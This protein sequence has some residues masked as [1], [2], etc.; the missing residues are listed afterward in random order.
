MYRAVWVQQ[1]SCVN[2][3]SGGFE[4][5]V[6]L[7]PGDAP[8]PP[9]TAAR[10]K[11]KLPIANA[12]TSA[13][14]TRVIC[15]I[16]S[17]RVNIDPPISSH[18]VDPRPITP[19]RRAL[20]EARVRVPASK[21][22][23]NR[24][25]VLSAIGS[26]RSRIVV[27]EMDPGDDVHAMAEALTALG[28]EVRWDAGHIDVT[29]LQVPYAHASVDARDAGTV[30]RFISALAA[31]SDAETR[32]DGS[33]RMRGR[34]MA[35]IAAAL[36]S[37]GATVD[38]EALPFVIH[39]PLRGGEVSVPGYE[40]SQFASALLLVAPRM[41]GGLSLRISGELVSAPFIDMTATALEG[42]GVRVERASMRHF[43]VAP[44]KV[45]A[46]SVTIPGDLTAATYPAAAAAI[47]GGSVTIENASAT[48][49]VGG[50][51]DAR[52][53]DLIAEMG[54]EVSGGSRA[55]TVRRR[56]ALSG[57]VANVA[58]CSDVFPTLA[59]IA[60]Q[61]ATPTELDGLAHT[62]RQESD[63]LRAV[64]AAITALGGRARAFADG[65]RIEPAPLHDGVVD[66]QGD[67]RIAMAFSV[68]GL[69]V[70]GV[71]IAGWQSVAKTFPSFYEMLRSLR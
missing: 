24:E 61:A 9:G 43:V 47:L 8:M 22:I 65:I 17:P 26:G 7:A 70:P 18:P 45:K 20:E 49:H 57:V 64:A 14:A 19:L 6:A 67:H 25:L 44:Q 48:H 54:C 38:G 32:V 2:V 31:L 42:R 51:G 71:A 60:T 11:T 37:L 1:V 59:V 21:S 30:A 39:G 34:P 16:R 40:S 5:G 69:L 15:P 66:A 23:A 62:R 56:G 52:F 50:Q 63:R 4:F 68:L 28:H 41:R 55:I 58:D 46:R 13:I 10:P 3:T 35:A 33:E 29:P 12:K 36:R 27:G 53:F